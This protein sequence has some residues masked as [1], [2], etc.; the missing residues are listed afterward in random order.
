MDDTITL[1]RVGNSVGTIFSK[2]IL[3]LLN[4]EEGTTLHVTKTAN[5]IELSPYDPGFASDM[6]A[7]EDIARRYKNTLHKLAK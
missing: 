3:A 4:A 2:D 5:G 7:G 6:E 1:R